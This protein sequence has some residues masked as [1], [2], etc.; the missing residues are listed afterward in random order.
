MLK[1]F[2][3]Q[4]EFLPSFPVSHHLLFLLCPSLS[5]A[6]PV[7]GL[8]HQLEIIRMSCSLVLL[9]AVLPESRVKP[10]KQNS[11]LPSCYISTRRTAPFHFVFLQHRL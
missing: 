6:V 8:A 10:Q 9:N 11:I 5:Q 4:H 2:Q 3:S 1:V 7:D